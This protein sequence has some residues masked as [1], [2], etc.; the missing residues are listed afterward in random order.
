MFR[1]RILILLALFLASGYVAAAQPV[2]TADL[3]VSGTD[4]PDPVNAGDNIIYSITATNLGP[5]AAKNVSFT[6]ALGSGLTFVSGTN[7]AA[8][9]GTV[10]CTIG[11]MSV[12]SVARDVTVSVDAAASGSISSALAIASSHPHADDPNPG[13]NSSSIST[14]VIAAPNTPP[15]ANGQNVSTDE[16]TDLAITLTGSDAENDPL[17]FSVVNG[18]SNGALS[19]TEPNITYTPNEN[20]TGSDSFT[21]KANDGEDDSANATINIT[22]DPVNDAPVA[23]NDSYNV[24]EDG[25][26]TAS[27][28]LSNDNDIDGDG[29]SAQ[30]VSDVT[31]GSLSL[32]SDGSFTYNPN[33]N[34][35][36]S[37][38]FTYTAN[39]GSEDSNIATV[40]INVNPLNDAPAAV[41]D[42][43]NVDEDGSLNVP[44]SGVLGN[45]NDEDGDGLSA[46]LV[47][48][49]TNGTLSLNSDGSFSYSPNSNFNGSDSFTYTAND[50]SEGSN[51]ATVTITVN[52]VNDAPSS[53]ADS[54]SVD[55]DET[56]DVPANGVL[57]NDNDIDGNGL[58]AVLVSDPPDGSV[59]LNADGSFSY[60]PDENFSGSDSFTYKAND[61]SEDSGTATVT[62]TVDP[63]NDAPEAENDSYNVNEDESLSVPAVN[64]VLSNDSDEEDDSLTAILVSSTSNGDLNLNDDGSF[65][66]SPS[67]DFNGSDSFTYKAN[68]GNDDSEVVT[69]TITVDSVNDDPVATDDAATT[70]Q[71]ADVDV[72]VVDND[73]D[74]DDDTLTVTNVG[75][76]SNGTATN[77]NDGTVTYSPNPGF[78]GNDSFTYTIED[79]NGGSDTATVN[80]TVDQVVTI[81][82]DDTN[83]IEPLN[84]SVNATLT[85]TLS[86]AS[87]SDITFDFATSDG[88]A[89]EGSDYNGDSDSVTIPAGE[90]SATITIQVLADADLFEENE[91]ILVNLSN[92]NIAAFNDDQGTIT[93]AEECMFCDDFEDGVTASNW[94]YM[95]PNWI[96]STG[97]LRGTPTKRKAI[98]VA[99]PAFDGCTNCSINTTMATAGG[100]SN[101][102]SLYAFFVDKKN[103]VELMMKETTDKWLLRHRVNGKVVKKAKGAAVILPNTNYSVDLS[104]DGTNFVVKV[105]GQTLITMPAS[106]IVPN[107]TVGYAVRNTTGIFGHI[108]VN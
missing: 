42:S 101:R 75:G 29:L 91:T 62:I 78:S 92:A 74:A 70:D 95:K 51:V 9:A 43:Y 64:G 99:N 36:G 86:A 4:S 84:G 50:G 106:T 108:L 25:S 8:A 38:S 69:V 49:V 13:N 26:L 28:V 67:S 32:N 93:I 73:S 34:F 60:T 15:T 76:A 12:G 18:P 100:D 39:D 30:L 37:D 94:N 87:D 52:P 98:V 102:V 104:F 27:G 89:T 77:N 19:G 6:I 47:N 41:N 53:T 71:D 20:F 3:T 17:S 44:A 96:E 21:F 57:A 58:T 2:D 40:T 46:Q 55:E 35:E 82:I 7:C 81:S 11:N 88:T 85:I 1:T 61:G 66:Y 63:V 79:G 103:T 80:I 33:S 31:N 5:D 22:V 105:D 97:S 45:D 10:T 24:D 23:V 68:D 72:N 14:N 90:T 48:N 107:G 16:E 56:L 65:E 54:Y 83:V 59:T